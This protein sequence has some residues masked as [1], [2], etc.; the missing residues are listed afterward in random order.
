N[1]PRRQMEYIMTQ[2][3]L[4]SVGSAVDQYTDYRRTGYPVLFDPKNPTMAPGG[5]VTPPEDGLKQ[6]PVQLNRNY[7]L[8]LPWYQTELETNEN[9][10]SQKTDLASYKVFW[11]P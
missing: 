1:N 3:W 2:K 10:P 5:L 8:S 9:A 6:V 11:L 7:P 4:S